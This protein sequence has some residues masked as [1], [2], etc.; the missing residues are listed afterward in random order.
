MDDLIYIKFGWTVQPDNY[1]K[2]LLHRVDRRFFLIGTDHWKEMIVWL[3]A[4]LENDLFSL[5]KEDV[6]EPGEFQ[7]SGHYRLVTQEQL[8]HLYLMVDGFYE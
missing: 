6:A 5:V 4:G 2:F 1:G 7:L 8:A 3:D